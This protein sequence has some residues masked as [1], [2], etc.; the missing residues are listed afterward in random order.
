MRNEILIINQAQFGHHTDYNQYLSF[1]K[2]KYSLSYICFNENKFRYDDQSISIK[3]IKPTKINLFSKIKFIYKSIKASNDKDLIFIKYFP[4]CSIILLFKLNSRKKF[5]LDL[6]SGAVTPSKSRNA[7]MNWL[8][9]LESMLFNSVSVISESLARKL[10]IKNYN[11]LPLGSIKRYSEKKEF[12]LLRLL[13]IG[14]FYNRNLE[15]AIKGLCKYIEN[16][17][18]NQFIKWTI[19]GGSA[20]KEFLQLNLLVRSLG[21]E[22]IIHFTGYVP[23]EDLSTYYTKHNV[24]VSFIPITDYYNCQPPTKIFEYALAGLF[25]LATATEESKRYINENNGLL[26]DDTAEG[27]YSALIRLTNMQTQINSDEIANS[28]IEFEWQKLLDKFLN[29]IISKIIYKHCDA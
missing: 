18:S 26:F 6:R 20:S 24:G 7:I 8:I 2:N 12:K 22:N 13:Y 28:L 16:N 21:M 1:L 5:H 3:Y 27:F 4:L 11:L 10:K 17:K 14:T 23:D 29:P 9:H 15:I 19:I 25:T